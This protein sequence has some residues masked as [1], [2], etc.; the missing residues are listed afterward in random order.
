MARYRSLSSDKTLETIELLGYRI[1]ERFPK[2]NLKGVC[3]SLLE[4]A[5]DSKAKAAWIARPNYPLRVGIGLVIV[6]GMATLGFSLSLLEFK[7]SSIGL[8]DLVLVFDAAISDLVFMGA[9]IFFLVTIE[10]R[11]KRKRAL[12][13]LHELRSLAHVVDMHQLTK[14]P[15]AILNSVSIITPS[16]PSREMT[17]FELNRYLD[18]CSELLSL[19]GKIAA[20][21]IQESRDSVILSAVTD[22]ENLTND[23]NRQIW[24]KLIILQASYREE[25]GKTGPSKRIG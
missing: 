21:Y 7:E 13:A 24:Q 5:Q 11:I 17:S 19:T 22:I 12:L 23:L 10:S 20:L 14:D 16:S 1:E 4:V 9:A 25:N 3:D 2:S 6:V 15:N 8:S 18:Y